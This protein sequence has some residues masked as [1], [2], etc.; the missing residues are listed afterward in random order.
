MNPYLSSASLMMAKTMKEGY[1]YSSC[2]G[3]NNIRF[4]MPLELIENKGRYGLGYKCTRANWRRMIEE[5]I[6]RS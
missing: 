1:K 4:V 3:Q 6:E 5:K 2:L